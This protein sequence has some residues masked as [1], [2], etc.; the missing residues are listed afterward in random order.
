MWRSLQIGQQLWRGHE[1]ASGPWA[2]SM[3]RSRHP[4]G[5]TDRMNP[6]LHADFRIQKLK[7]GR[8]EAP[9]IVVDNLLADADALVEL[10]AG[11]VFSDV[12][13]YYPGVR[14]KVPLSY[15]R[16]MIEK[17][18]GEIAGCFGL[19]ASTLRFTAC[20]FSLVTTPP[21]Q[22]AHPQRIPHVDSLI[23]NELAFIHYLFKANLGGTAFYRHRATGFEY[24]NEGRVAQY[25]RQ[26]EIERAGP[27]SPPAEYINGDTP[28]YEQLDSREGKFNR[29]LIYRRTSLHSGALARNF[30][31]DINPRTG[32]LSINGFLA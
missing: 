18:G 32:R 27:H 29:L 23:S 30:T 6:I 26:V 15:Q 20:H 21:E 31:P 14:T 4:E 3:R 5:A 1:S 19:V 25:A 8:E 2:G 24:V 17:L 9:L 28:L 10:A 12:A 13:T 22:L 16:F 11:K 7:I